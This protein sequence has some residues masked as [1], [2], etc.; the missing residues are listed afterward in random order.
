MVVV[1][2]PASSSLKRKETG[3]KEGAGKEGQ[4]AHLFSVPFM[5]HELYGQFT[6][7]SSFYQQGK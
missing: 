4:R 6:I 3:I 2:G 5:C 7:S 1:V